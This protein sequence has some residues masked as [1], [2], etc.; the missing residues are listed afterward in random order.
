ML[1]GF[2]EAASSNPTPIRLES[3]KNEGVVFVQGQK[4]Q[5][6][7]ENNSGCDEHVYLLDVSAVYAAIIKKNYSTSERKERIS[8]Q[9]EM[10]TT[11]EERERESQ[12]DIQGKREIDDTSRKTHT[13][14]HTQ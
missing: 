2:T 6:E 8:L 9:L 12:F 13:R 14:R 3:N 4:S 10:L 7:W 11:V 1:V 5:N